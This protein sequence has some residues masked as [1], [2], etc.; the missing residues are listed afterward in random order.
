MLITLLT[1][2]ELIELKMERLGEAARARGLVWL[3]LSIPDVST[4]SADGNAS[5]PRSARWS[6][7]LP[8][9]GAEWTCTAKGS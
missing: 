1:L 3:H 6:T 7:T 5:G 8:I 2:A 4:A 9:M